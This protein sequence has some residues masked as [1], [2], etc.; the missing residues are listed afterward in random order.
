MQWAMFG[1]QFGSNGD[2]GSGMWLLG[3]NGDTGGGLRLLGSNADW[4]GGW[5]AME[6]GVVA[7]QQWRLVLVCGC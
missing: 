4:C 1:G 7:G 3:I 2:N 6:T 5:T